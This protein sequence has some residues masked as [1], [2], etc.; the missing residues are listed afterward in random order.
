MKNTALPSAPVVANVE[1]PGPVHASWVQ[2]KVKSGWDSI[3]EFGESRQNSTPTPTFSS[4]TPPAS[5]TVTTNGKS[6]PGHATM[7][8]TVDCA[9]LGTPAPATVGPART[10]R[11]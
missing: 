11:T 6:P 4:G 7:H 1:L 8:G 5:R 2:Q 9:G 10:P 3:A